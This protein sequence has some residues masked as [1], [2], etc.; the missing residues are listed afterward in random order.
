MT[1][2]TGLLFFVFNY[3]MNSSH[4]FLVSINT[5]KE[6]SFKNYELLY[7]FVHKLTF[8]KYDSFVCLNPT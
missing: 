5:C 4:N 6:S 2:N 7:I 1:F 8:L 3:I